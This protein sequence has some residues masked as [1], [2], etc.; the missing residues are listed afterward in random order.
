MINRYYGSVA[1]HDYRNLMLALDGHEYFAILRG[2]GK[3]S[4]L[5]VDCDRLWTSA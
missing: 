4:V 5:V 2:K 3:E 1:L